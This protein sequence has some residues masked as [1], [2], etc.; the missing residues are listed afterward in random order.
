MKKRFFLLLLPLF[1]NAQTGPDPNDILD[2][3]SMID[4]MVNS[5]GGQ[6]VYRQ[7]K[8]W[9]TEF[10]VF[11]EQQS[12]LMDELFNAQFIDI[13]QAY[14]SYLQTHS[15]ADLNELILIFARQETY[16]R[17]L[18]TP[19]QLQSYRNRFAE[20][21]GRRSEERHKAFHSLFISDQKLAQYSD[22]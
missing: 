7:T 19:Q 22:Q 10:L 16:F 15:P 21:Y 18:L 13:S 14:R 4:F 8:N 9:C 2:R 20:T 11:N 1:L 6:M 5:P 17:K 12:E 3:L